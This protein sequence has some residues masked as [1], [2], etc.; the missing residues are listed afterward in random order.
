MTTW[1]KLLPLEINDVEKLIEPE[2]EVKTDDVIQGNMDPALCK[3]HT[4]WRLASKHSAY[5]RYQAEF[6]RQMTL[7]EYTVKITESTIKQQ[8]LQIL[9]W[10][11]VYDDFKLWDK[12]PDAAVRKG[13][14][15]V[16]EKPHPRQM[17]GFL[18]FLGIGQDD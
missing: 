18:R 10:V 9:F 7:E 17:P 3:L 15:I 6:D 5:L 1:V 14:V 16:V 11:S 13:F 4:L 2:D 8:A 12:Y